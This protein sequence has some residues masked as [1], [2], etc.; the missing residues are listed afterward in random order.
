MHF[1]A[2]DRSM[3]RLSDVMACSTSGALLIPPYLNLDGLA[4]R[5]LNYSNGLP[6]TPRR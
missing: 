3:G 2:I 5:M 6:L 4:D 1:L